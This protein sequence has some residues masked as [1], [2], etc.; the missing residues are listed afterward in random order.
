[1]TDISLENVAAIAGFY[2]LDDPE[3]HEAWLG[4]VRLDRS[5]ME[6][7]AEADIPVEQGTVDVH[8]LTVRPVRG[9]WFD[10]KTV[11][12]ETA[13]G[14]DETVRE[15]AEAV[16]NGETSAAELTERAIERAHRQR[17]LNAFTHLFED[18]ARAEAAEI[19]SRVRRGESVGPLA[20]MTV[21]VKDI[22]AVE[23]YSMTGGTR[24]MN[25]PPSKEDAV[26]VSK[27]RRAGAVVL[28]M[29]NL[30]GL[31][32]GAM[33]VNPD[34]GRV[35]NPHREQALAGGSSGG[36]GAAVGADIVGA[37]IGTD[38]GGSVR[39]PAACCGA[40]GLKP[41]FG[42]V[43][44]A[45][46][47]PLGR[48]LDHVGPLTK[49]VGDAALLLEVLSDAPFSAAS[50][51]WRNLEGAVV[52]IPRS[53]FFDHLAPEVEDAVN[54]CIETVEELGGEVVDADVPS[55]RYAPAAQLFTIAAEA[56][57]VHRQML[58]ERAESLPEDVRL[59]LEMGMF[60]FASDYV[61]AQRLRGM[62]QRE[63][64]EALEKA[65]VLLTPTMA[66]TVP[67]EDEK[68][69]EAGGATWPTQ[70]ALSRLSMPFTATGHP[71]L[72]F[73]WSADGRGCPIGMQLVGRPM[74]EIAVLSAARILE[75]QRGDW[76]ER[77][78]G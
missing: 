28:G 26:C 36:S 50:T 57:D 63:V 53:Y 55:M 60:F 14:P 61:R 65:D 59:R 10:R 37:A 54:D 43:S 75:N 22:I 9:K 64:D 66:V 76:K 5:A 77:S 7:L 4:R 52:G 67:D 29:A 30:H 12:A 23:G 46:V 68:E 74:E 11:S 78:V 73:P 44:T 33:S 35:L 71:A 13:T 21:A 49:T 58:G 31:A 20:V 41:T 25:L 56:F 17:H 69:V 42:R 1:M 34:Y 6:L 72:T 40:V 24:V 47:Y 16:Q 48:T 38:T 15:R 51:V 19:D 62:I 27:V 39:I 2:E 18:G 70:F 45:G 8:S 3:R 32:Y